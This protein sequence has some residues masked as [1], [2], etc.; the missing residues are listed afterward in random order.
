MSRPLARILFPLGIVLLISIGASFFLRDVQV[1]TAPASTN[2]KVPRLVS[3]LNDDYELDRRLGSDGTIYTMQ[4]Y[5][6]LTAQAPD[7][8]QKW[9]TKLLKID[10]HAEGGDPITDFVVAPQGWIYAVS[11]SGLLYGIDSGGKISWQQQIYNARELAILSGKVEDSAHYPSHSPLLAGPTGDCYVLLRHHV[12]CFGDD[13]KRKY[14]CEL[15]AADETVEFMSNLMVGFQVGYDSTVY[16]AAEEDG[17]PPYEGLRAVSREGKL[18]WKKPLAGRC[19][20]SHYTDLII[21]AAGGMGDGRLTAYDHNWHKLWEAE[22]SP[23]V[24]DFDTAGNTYAITWDG[25]VVA[26]GPG[27]QELWRSPTTATI[28]MSAKGNGPVYTLDGVKGIVTAI[29]RTTGKVLWDTTPSA[30]EQAAAV[31]AQ[32]AE[33][34]HG[35][36]FT[37]GGASDEREIPY[38]LVYLFV[39]QQGT[40]Y[41]SGT[42][43][44]LF[45]AGP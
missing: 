28:E 44:W 45:A 6:W 21:D 1:K 7:G 3:K 40:A 17:R 8:T 34:S 11:K 25:H 41:F 32:A 5:E 24:I 39:A 27:G 12:A 35:G 15:R 18:L 29:D 42:A 36:Y 9:R 10:A 16:V 23:R 37:D 20:V 31:D 2:H 33:G 22:L 30:T 14:D 43:N 13:G 26:L 4:H 38:S 19:S